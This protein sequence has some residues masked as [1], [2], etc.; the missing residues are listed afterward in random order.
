MRF[1]DAWSPYPH[2]AD[3]RLRN[4]K[5]VPVGELPMDA[6]AARVTE[7]DEAAVWE[8]TRRVGVKI[9]PQ[10]TLDLLAAEQAWRDLDAEIAEEAAQVDCIERAL[11]DLVAKEKHPPVA[12]DNKCQV[13]IATYR[14][15]RALER[16]HGQL[17][18]GD[19]TYWAIKDRVVAHLEQMRNGERVDVLVGSTP[20]L[21]PER[22]IF[23]YALGWRVVWPP[24][25][26]T[27]RPWEQRL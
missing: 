21:K 24:R 22:R 7:G 3:E 14:A 9:I 15:M 1:I 27:F 5:H 4:I 17:V 11:R 2:G 20:D 10:T 23:V 8:Y 12:A 26:L 19:E 6:L 18:M 16:A 25:E 13:Y